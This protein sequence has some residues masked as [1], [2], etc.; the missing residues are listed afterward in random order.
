[1]AVITLARLVGSGGHSIA[2][3]LADRLGFRSCDRH[4][5]R[6]EAELLGFDLPRAFEEFAR[7]DGVPP[8]SFAGSPRLYASYGEL[9]FDRAILGRDEDQAPSGRASFL[10]AL[11]SQQREILLA[12]QAVTYRLAA[13]DNI[14]LI[15]A[16]TQLLLA[17]TPGVLRIKVV[18]SAEVRI[19]R[20]AAA[21][22]LSQHEAQAGIA[23]ADLEQREYNRAILGADWDEPLLWDVTINT[24]HL[25]IATISEWVAGLL[26]RPPYAGELPSPVI[27]AL[28]AAAEINHR[29]WAQSGLRMATIVA[30]PQGEAVV[31]RGDAPTDSLHQA[32]REVA[33]AV[34]SAERLR[35]EVVITAGESYGGEW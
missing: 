14:I 5:M 6:R 16:G 35:D 9:E 15:G 28:N 24:D 31:L 25:S 1:M 19:E 8:G 27:E 18:A 26:T 20:L 23:R 21:Y 13:A 4:D 7:E 29:L 17:E 11:M 30:V 34:T 12:L 32:A 3:A 2:A 22:G 10:D 33:L